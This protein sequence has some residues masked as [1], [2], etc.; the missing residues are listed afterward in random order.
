VQVRANGID[1]NYELAG[2]GDVL[3]LVHGAGDSLR[4]WWRQTPEFSKRYRVLTYDIRG[5]GATGLPD[6]DVNVDVLA[7]DLRELLRALDV[8]SAFVLGYSMGGRI[9]L[10]FALRQPEMARALV[11]ANSSVG[12]GP[13]PEGAA[14]RRQA[15]IDALR[16]G[17]IDAVAERMTELSFSPGVKERDPELFCRYAA[18]KRASEPQAFA[19]VW[20]AMTKA[21]PADLSG[22][23]CP[24]LIIAG[25][26]DSFVSMEAARATQAAIAGSRLEALPTGHAAAIEAPD[27]FNR[28][29]VD[30]LAAVSSKPA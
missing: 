5:F 12:I 22:L 29:V 28:I 19:R 25:E 26:R 1:I 20:E 8:D 17:E 7:A 16:R 2:E 9:A 4:M 18:I 14:E 15:L 6:G 30:F 3:V 10:Q 21:G 23:R 13:A 11:L 27:E 24:T